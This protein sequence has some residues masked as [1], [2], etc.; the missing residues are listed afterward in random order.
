M[1]DFDD[2]SGTIRLVREG[3]PCRRG[4]FARYGTRRGETIDLSGLH[5]LDGHGEDRP[6]WIDGDTLALSTDG[7]TALYAFEDHRL[8]KRGAIPSG[9]AAICG[10]PKEPLPALA[11][12]VSGGALAELLADIGKDCMPASRER[13]CG[14]EHQTGRHHAFPGGSGRR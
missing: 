5:L 6:R 14:D 10:G 1:P 9:E 8:V 4:S 13:A 7:E 12:H 3:D 2:P 11:N